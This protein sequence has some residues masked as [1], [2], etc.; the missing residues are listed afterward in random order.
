M[1]S[2]KTNKW[3]KHLAFSVIGF[4]LFAAFIYFLNEDSFDKLK[5]IQ[6]LPAFGALLS[7][8]GI[9][10]SI[11]YRWG[12]IV[13]TLEKR[14]AATWVQYYHY[15]IQSRALGFILPK[16]LTDFGVRIM[17]LKKSHKSKLSDASISVFLD[18]LYDLMVIMV[19]LISVLPY[20]LGLLSG[21]H[22]FFVI[23]ALLVLFGF[24]LISRQGFLLK[25]I[26]IVLNL[27]VKVFSIFPFIKKKIPQQIALP[28]F[29]KNI[30]RSLYFASILK[31]G[32]TMARFVAFAYALNIVVAPEIIVLGTP[33]GQLGYLFSF[34]PG[35]LGVFEAGWFGILKLAKVSSQAALIFVVGQRVLTVILVLIL[36]FISQVIFIINKK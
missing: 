14:K 9:T 4:A 29:E 1:K 2:S 10:G 3:F 32:F 7:T 34:T 24:L 8:I 20:W 17:W 28:D 23:G 35:G 27:L 13:N 16:D 12:T 6:W 25:I 26:R 5:N 11:A 18:R 19:I 33:L 21:I 22:T 36:A 15:F 31:I 30:T